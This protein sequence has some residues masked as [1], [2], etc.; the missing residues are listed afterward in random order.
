ML[1]PLLAGADHVD[2]QAV[3]SQRGLREFIAGMMSYQPG[4]MSFLYKLR[5]LFVAMLGMRQDAVPSAP[6]WRPADVPMRPG[7]PAS[8]F[9]VRAS[10]EDR[11]WVVDAEERHLRATL[12]VVRAAQRFSLVTIVHYRHWTGP[13]YFNVIRPFHHLVIRGMARAGAATLPT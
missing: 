2:V 9:T 7:E 11:L 13:I 3:S 10:E 1:T 8:F 6:S 4:W 12:A 5:K